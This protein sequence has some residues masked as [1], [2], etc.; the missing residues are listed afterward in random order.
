MSRVKKE[1]NLRPYNLNY[2]RLR[3]LDDFCNTA[4]LNYSDI[5]K[6]CGLAHTSVS[7]WFEVD[8]CRLSVCHKLIEGK[9]FKLTIYLTRDVNEIDSKVAIDMTDML[10]FDEAGRYIPKRLGFLAVAMK[11]YG[12][13]RMQLA[14]DMQIAYTS[15]KA[16]FINDDMYVSRLFQIADL[17]DFS[18]IINISK[19][20]SDITPERLRDDKM[21]RRY[22]STLILESEQE[23]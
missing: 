13:K 11:R 15:L 3:F 6:I 5:A 17:C 4:N 23:I 7:H 21:P 20:E 1:G 12:I 16:Y 18:V 8:D 10:D 2:R 9:G 19:K 14:K 22:I